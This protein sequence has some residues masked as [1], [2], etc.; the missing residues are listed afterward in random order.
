[1]QAIKVN[2][3]S[4][5]RTNYGS[6]YGFAEKCTEDKWHF[7]ARR[8]PPQARQPILQKVCDAG[9]NC[10][11]C[12][13]KQGESGRKSPQAT[14]L[15]KKTEREGKRGEQGE[16]GGRG[17]KRGKER[18]RRKKKEKKE[19]KEERKKEKHDTEVREDG[20]ELEVMTKRGAQCLESSPERPICARIGTSS[21]P[22]A[23]AQHPVGDATLE[24]AKSCR[25]ASTS[26]QVPGTA[27]T[28]E[29]CCEPN[30]PG[31]SYGW[32]VQLFSPSL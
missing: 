27:E 7:P 2:G 23:T 26:P 11:F 18:G 16:E 10:S 32:Q 14:Q 21:V 3:T 29:K 1:M 9:W 19:R 24:P 22:Q 15:K 5:M 28:Q 12:K 6:K 13:R 17:K 8:M 31:E 20:Q 25:A 30:R 4:H